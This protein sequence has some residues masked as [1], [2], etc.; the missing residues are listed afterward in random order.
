MLRRLFL[1]LEKLKANNDEVALKVQERL[2]IIVSWAYVICLT[3]ISDVLDLFFMIIF[4]LKYVIRLQV[5]MAQLAG[6]SGLFVI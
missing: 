2:R 3:W 6:C 5:G 4:D 1:N